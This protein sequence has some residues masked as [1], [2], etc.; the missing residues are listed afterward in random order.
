MI[1][2]KTQ[3]MSIGGH[4]QRRAGCLVGSRDVVRFGCRKVAVACGARQMP[5]GSV[6]YDFGG[7]GTCYG[8]KPEPEVETELEKVVTETVDGVEKTDESAAFQT[9]GEEEKA[10]ATQGHGNTQTLEIVTSI[11]AQGL[12]TLS[13]KELQALARKHGIKANAKSVVIKEQLVEIIEG[14]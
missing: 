12:E 5:D 10:K 2:G 7:E 14:K 3:W 11:T 9:G 6:I 8:S 13:R 1:A 4:R